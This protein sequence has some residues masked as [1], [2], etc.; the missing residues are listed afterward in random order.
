MRHIESPIQWALLI[1]IICVLGVLYALS[2]VAPNSVGA[3]FLPLLTILGLL[4]VAAQIWQDRYLRKRREAR[5]RT[6]EELRHEDYAFYQRYEDMQHEGDG[7]PSQH[8]THAQ[9]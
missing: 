7:S 8:G 9:P 3:G 6:I 5:Q 2:F 1:G 4:A